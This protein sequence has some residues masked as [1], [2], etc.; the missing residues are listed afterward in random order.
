MKAK[1]YLLQLQ[2][3][4]IKVKHKLEEI[5]ALKQ[6]ATSSGA[7][8]DGERVQ[9]SVSGDKIPRIVAKYVDM[10]NKINRDIDGYIDLKDKIINEIHSLKNKLY[11]DILFKRYVEFKS[12]EKIAVELGYSYIHIR[13]M[14][15]YALLEFQKVIDGG[16]IHDLKNKQENQM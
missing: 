10:E 8:S 4:D 6:L 12:L 15:G 3:I 16:G 1:E 2:D 14:H 5:E 7:V 9:T 13:R 11:M